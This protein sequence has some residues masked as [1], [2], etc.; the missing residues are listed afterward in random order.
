MLNSTDIGKEI[1]LARSEPI[2]LPSVDREMSNSASGEENDE[3]R[4]LAASF[5]PT[6]KCGN[7]GRFTSRQIHFGKKSLAMGLPA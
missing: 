6:Y 4:R 1:R 3:L 7:Q 5:S 2:H